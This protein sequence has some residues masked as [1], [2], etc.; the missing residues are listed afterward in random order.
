MTLFLVTMKF[1]RSIVALWCD[2]FAQQCQFLSSL[3]SLVTSNWF[4]LY[5]DS[6]YCFLLDLLNFTVEWL[7][8]YTD[9]FNSADVITALTPGFLTFPSGQLPSVKV[10]LAN[11]RMLS[12]LLTLE[13]SRRSYPS[14]YYPSQFDLHMSLCSLCD[15]HYHRMK[16]LLSTLNYNQ[17]KTSYLAGFINKH[18]P[19][20]LFDTI[21][22]LRLTYSWFLLFAYHVF[23]YC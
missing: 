5:S 2:D 3:R 6:F 15:V 23:W 21:N 10:T 12:Y 14:N 17:R 8:S 13:A 22:R 7:K 11:S 18:N 16:E 19:R 20:L 4:S 9:T 1:S